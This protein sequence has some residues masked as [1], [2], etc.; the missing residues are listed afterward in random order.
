V[1]DWYEH[2]PLVAEYQFN[3]TDLVA[4]D[5]R[6]HER[7]DRAR[8]DLS[9]AEDSVARTRLRLDRHVAARACLCPRPRAPESPEVPRGR[10]V[11]D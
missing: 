2:L 7:L 9:G 11:F 8:R 1:E 10:G 5:P 3:A 4:L 6:G